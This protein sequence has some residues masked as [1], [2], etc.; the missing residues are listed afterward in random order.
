[1][2]SLCPICRTSTGLEAAFGRLVDIAINHDPEALAMHAIN[3]L[4]PRCGFDVPLEQ[5][6]LNLKRHT[7]D[8]VRWAL[9]GG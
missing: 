7:R 9:A 5:I 4:A 6:R 8:I 3:H 2:V 1:M